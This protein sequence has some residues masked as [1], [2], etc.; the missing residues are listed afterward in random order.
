MENHNRKYLTISYFAVLVTAMAVYILS[1]APG[2]LWQ[3]SGMFYY[4]IWH[5]DI[6]GKLGLALSHPLYHLIGIAA[7]YIPW[8]EFAYRVNLIS[9][10]AGAVAIANVFLLLRLWLGENLPAVLGATTLALSWTCWQFSS[11]AKDWTL[12]LAIFSTELIMLLQYVKTKRVGFLYLLAFFNGL[13]LADNMCAVFTLACYLVLW[14]VL[15]T[16]KQITLRHIAIMIALWIMG[17]APYEYLVIKNIIQTHNFAATMASVFF[18]NSWK[19]NTLNAAVSGRIIKENLIF[20]AYNFSTPNVIF[21]FIG[22]YGLG[23]ISPTRGF[24]GVFWA[25]LI[26][27]FVFAFRYTIPDRYAFFIPFFCLVSILTGVGFNSVL[28]GLARPYRRA[29]CRT[30]FILALLPIP[31]YI[32][33]PIVAEKMQF[34]LS[35]GREIPYRNSYTWF[36]RPWQTGYNGAER[37]AKE[38]LSSVEKEAIIIADGTTVCPLWY[39]Q[40]VKGISPQVKVVSSHGSYQNPVAFP[41][42]DTIERLMADHAVYVVSPV[43][44]YCPRFLLDRYNFVRSGVLWRV[45]EQK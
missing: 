3:D 4:R 9:A 23:K 18:G 41:T 32:V 6:E 20:I 2:V 34:N 13:A 15:L 10:V 7:K 37:F 27:F 33:A 17:A 11:I 35:T 8:G 42:E 12:Y 5:N 44:G 30:V 24:A 45:V 38:A 14:A 22:L 36:L 1:C 16:Q 21:F 40:T 43:A 19:K 39:V 25:S 26:L 29:L 28:A 31:V